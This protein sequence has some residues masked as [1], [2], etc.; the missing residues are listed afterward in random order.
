MVMV[1]SCQG[2][3]QGPPEVRCVVSV[4]FSQQPIVLISI[5]YC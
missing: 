1:S 3:G 2:P 4:V 5:G